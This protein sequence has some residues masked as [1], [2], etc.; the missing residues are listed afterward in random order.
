MSAGIGK[1]FAYNTTKKS[2]NVIVL[3]GWTGASYE[4]VKK[5]TIYWKKLMLV[6]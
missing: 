2:P 6:Q 3:F 5:S 1:I 4:D